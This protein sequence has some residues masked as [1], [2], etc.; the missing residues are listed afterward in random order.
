MCML[1]QHVCQRYRPRLVECHCSSPHPYPSFRLRLPR[2]RSIRG[3]Q[4]SSPSSEITKKKKGNGSHCLFISLYS[5]T[6]LQLL[7]LLRWL[8]SKSVRRFSQWDLRY[9]KYRFSQWD[10]WYSKYRRSYWVKR[11][12]YMYVFPQQW[13]EHT[14]DRLVPHILKPDNTQ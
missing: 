6:Q 5:V 12:T 4:S 10:L 3:T 2:L 9:S 1:H 7:V 8:Q 11:L 13:V 14:S